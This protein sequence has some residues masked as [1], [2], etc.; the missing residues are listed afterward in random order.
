[1]GKGL[2]LPLRGYL[3]IS[4]TFFRLHWGAT[5]ILWMETRNAVK[6]PKMQRTVCTQKIIH[7]T[8]SVVLKS[9]SPGLR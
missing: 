5:G 9:K 4:E 6:H 1:M 7:L 8:V 2:I 3:A